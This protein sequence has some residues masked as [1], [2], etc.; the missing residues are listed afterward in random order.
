MLPCLTSSFLSSA[1]AAGANDIFNWTGALFDADNLGGS[2]INA[3][4]GADN[5]TNND[6]DTY[7]ALGRPIQGQSFITGTNANGYDLTAFTVR[8]VGYSNNVASDANNTYW[9]LSDYA[10]FRVRVGEIR[11][12]TNFFPRSHQYAAAGGPGNPGATGSANGPGTY[13][14]FTLDSGSRSK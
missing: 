11:D 14:T 3:N 9:N 12:G 13:V 5:G 1:P 4:G 8:V 10:F 2:G 7:V 6:N